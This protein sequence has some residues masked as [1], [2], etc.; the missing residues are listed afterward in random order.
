MSFFVSQ[1]RVIIRVLGS[2]DRLLTARLLGTTI[3]ILNFAR[4]IPGLVKLSRG[5]SLSRELFKSGYSGVD[6][7][8][9]KLEILRLKDLIDGRFSLYDVDATYV[10]KPYTK[11]LMVNGN[12]LPQID[13]DRIKLSLEKNIGVDIEILGY[14]RYR[15]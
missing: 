8:F 5:S 15:C 1:F 11:R 13:S 3:G 7:Q 14:I 6:L 10:A 4:G 2:V 12:N 9:S